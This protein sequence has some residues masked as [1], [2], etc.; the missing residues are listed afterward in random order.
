VLA[1]VLALAVVVGA[2]FL[3][4][5]LARYLSARSGGFMSG[6][7]IKILDR[8]PLGKDKY[9]LVVAVRGKVFFLGA[10]ETVTVL[11]TWPEDAAEREMDLP[12][13]APFATLVAKWRRMRP[14]QAGKES[15]GSDA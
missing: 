2:I 4:Y 13:A 11:E 5:A 10:A 1:V 15:D 7:Q 6:R 3:T 8:V 14:G 12:Q 9:L